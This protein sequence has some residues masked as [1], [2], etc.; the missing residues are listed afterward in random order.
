MERQQ[1]HKGN[2][3]AIHR[4]VKHFTEKKLKDLPPGRAFD[5]FLTLCQIG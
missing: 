1:A 3:S 5:T 2:L 4:S